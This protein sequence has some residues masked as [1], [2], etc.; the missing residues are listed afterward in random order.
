M[1]SFKIISDFVPKGDQPTAIETLS[2]GLLSGKKH[3]VLLGVTGSGKTFTMANVVER[4]QKPT[5]VMAPNKTL[6]A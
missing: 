2:K 6:A 3:Q 4:I 1:P 5:L